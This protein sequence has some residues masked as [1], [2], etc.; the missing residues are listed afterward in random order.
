[1]NIVNKKIYFQYSANCL[2]T[3]IYVNLLFNPFQKYF[4]S[5]ELVIDPFVN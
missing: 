1:M 2:D 3:L 4:H 5:S